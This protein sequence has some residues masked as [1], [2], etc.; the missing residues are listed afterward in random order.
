MK[1]LLILLEGKIP[2]K[3]AK[4][5]ALKGLVCNTHIPIMEI[6]KYKFLIQNL[7]IKFGE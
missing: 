3:V 2:N 1:K 7:P 5:I 6:D 4:N